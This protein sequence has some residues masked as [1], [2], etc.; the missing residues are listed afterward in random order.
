MQQR[1]LLVDFIVI[2]NKLY[3]FMSVLEEE[4]FHV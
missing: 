1:I 4:L 2:I 3:E